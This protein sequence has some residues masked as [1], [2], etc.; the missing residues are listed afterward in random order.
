MTLVMGIYTVEMFYFLSTTWALSTY[1]FV[2]G[3]YAVFDFCKLP[4]TF[5]N[6]YASIAAALF[7][8]KIMSGR[9]CCIQRQ[10][11]KKKNSKRPNVIF[12]AI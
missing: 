8:R 12:F 7:F 3:I 1:R 10:E 5:L 6:V 9:T 11:I 2:S 4:R